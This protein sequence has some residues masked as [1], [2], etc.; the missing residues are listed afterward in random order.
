MIESILDG[1]A[2]GLMNTTELKR[3]R[4]KIRINVD[5]GQSKD[6]QTDIVD[7]TVDK[8][9]KSDKRAEEN[10]KELCKLMLK[11]LQ[12]KSVLERCD[13]LDFMIIIDQNRSEDG[14][15]DDIFVF[16]NKDCKIC[17]YSES[18]MIDDE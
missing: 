6:S 9:A 2:R 10:E 13:V 8:M 3:E 17:G 14:D 18:W 7:P 16:K 11:V 5:F 4:M 1:V 15:C 12:I